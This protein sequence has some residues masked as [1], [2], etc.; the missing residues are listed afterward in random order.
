MTVAYSAPVRRQMEPHA[1]RRYAAR[2][3]A[4]G[5]LRCCTR[6]SIELPRQSASTCERQSAA[7]SGS[8]RSTGSTGI[9]SL[10]LST[11]SIVLC[12]I[13]V[14]TKLNKLICARSTSWQPVTAFWTRMSRISCFLGIAALRQMRCCAVNRVWWPRSLYIFLGKLRIFDCHPDQFANFPKLLI[15]ARLAA[16]GVIHGQILSMSIVVP[17]AA[18][19]DK[20]SLNHLRCFKR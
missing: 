13:G 6:P 5:I 1:A 16:L 10:R 15:L 17:C 4:R 7:A 12:E 9:I 11:K 20:P 14:A 2:W 3:A 19:A 8:I 18:G